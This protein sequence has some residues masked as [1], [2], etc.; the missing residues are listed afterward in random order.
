M[1]ANG[2]NIGIVLIASILKHFKS[3]STEL[4]NGL[5]VSLSSEDHKLLSQYKEL[6]REQDEQ[7]TSLRGQLVSLQNENENLKLQLQ[8]QHSVVQQLRDQ[9]SLLKAQKSV[10]DPSVYGNSSQQ[11]NTYPS[12]DY[13]VATNAEP[14]TLL[15]SVPVSDVPS[16]GVFQYTDGQQ[17]HQYEAPAADPAASANAQYLV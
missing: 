4:N 9:N 11:A 6:I 13:Q 7:L 14:A 3:S 8:E 1:I 15:P 2:G 17:Q 16:A 10:F 12:Q 5:D